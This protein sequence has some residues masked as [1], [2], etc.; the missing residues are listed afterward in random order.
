MFDGT[1]ILLFF[2]NAM[3]ELVCY[4]MLDF[5]YGTSKT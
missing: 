4:G 5:L 1:L 2:L 3:A